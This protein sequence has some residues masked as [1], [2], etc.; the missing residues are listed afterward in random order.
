MADIDPLFDFID[1]F[2]QGQ[3][4]ANSD[5]SLTEEA[6]NQLENIVTSIQQ[7]TTVLGGGDII[8]NITNSETYETSVSD[9]SVKLEIDAAQLAEEMTSQPP[10]KEW[11]AELKTQ[12][13]IAVDHELVEGQRKATITLDGNAGH[14]DQ[15]ITG[16]GDGSRIKISG[17]N[18][19]LRYAGKRGKVIEIVNEGT[20]IHWY[21][22][23]AD[24]KEYWRG[25]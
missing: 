25:A 8:Q 17:G 9:S 14:N 6:I 10:P 5:G 24:G 21:K 18:I 20:F 3:K 7:T 12:D 19:E 2:R 11:H 4:W 16:N 15:I 1:W 23:I 13:Y 22:F